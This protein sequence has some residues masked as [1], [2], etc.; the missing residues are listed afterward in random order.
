MKQVR[1]IITFV[2]ILSMLASS[3]AF[4][5]TAKASASII[6]PVKNSVVS[7]DSLLLSVKVLDK[8]KISVTLFEE[9]EYIETKH[10]EE[11]DEDVD[12][13]KSIDVTDFT[14][15]IL[16]VIS[17]EYDKKKVLV[18]GEDE[19]KQ[20]LRAVAVTVPVS[21]TA[22]GEV[23]Y[24]SKK[25]ENLK[26]GLYR[27][28]VKVLDKDD[29][30]EEVYNSFVALQEKVDDEGKTQQKA[31]KVETQKTSLVKLITKFIKSLIK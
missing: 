15:E 7:D 12:I 2:L 22:T 19:E 26:P 8:K 24:F 1:R 11:K 13:L 25:V 31:V 29:K 16:D 28:Q 27:V 5:A 20:E 4:A 23:G 3:F 10:D 18:I 6:N 30:V 9:K 17:D 14:E 21:Y